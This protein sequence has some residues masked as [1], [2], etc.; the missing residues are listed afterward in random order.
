MEALV[1]EDPWRDGEC[2]AQSTCGLTAVDVAN[3]HDMSLY[4]IVKRVPLSCAA[5]LLAQM[6]RG[7]TWVTA[8]YSPRLSGQIP[9]Q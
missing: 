2:T 7:T 8:A 6:A 1:H 5:E 9:P 3:C 4:G